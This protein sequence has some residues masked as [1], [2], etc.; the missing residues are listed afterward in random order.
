MLASATAASSQSPYWQSGDRYPSQLYSSQPYSLTATPD[1]PQPRGLSAGRSLLSLGEGT[2]EQQAQSVL[3]SEAISFLPPGGDGD[4]GWLKR[5]EFS[6][7]L[8]QHGK[9]EQSILTVQPLYQSAGKRDTIFVQ[10]SVLR[11]AMFGEYRWT[12]NLGGG[13][14]RLL[15]GDTVLVGANTFFDEEI[16]HNH[17]RM[18]VGS[19]AKWGPLDLGF[20]DYVGLSGDRSVGSDIERALGGRDVSLASQVPFIPWV[21][22]AGRYFWWDKHA[23]ATDITGKALSSEIALLPSLTLSLERSDYDF[24]N[25]VA[26][27]QKSVFLTFKLAEWGAGPTLLTGPVVSDSVFETRDMTGQ[28]LAKVVR[29]NRIIVERRTQTNGGTVIVSRLN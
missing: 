22:V 24:S 7:G 27:P 17:K 21:K 2:V 25:Y 29:E 23:A 16:T 26:R 9:G 5:T 20:N 8:L 10:G 15:F 14:R 3:K 28:T 19:E 11:Y 12:T 18:S 4:W 13:Y 1:Q 6:G